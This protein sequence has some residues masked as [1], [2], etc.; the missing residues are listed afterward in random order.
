LD[1]KPISAEAFRSDDIEA[2]GV[3]SGEP[4]SLERNIITVLPSEL[5]LLVF[6]FLDPEDI[7]ATARTCTLFH[8]FTKDKSLWLA[9]S[10]RYYNVNPQAKVNDWRTYF[11]M[12]W[13]LS[14]SGSMQWVVPPRESIACLP[15]ERSRH[16]GNLVGDAIVFIGGND[17]RGDSFGDVH[18]FTPKT[19]KFRKKFVRNMPRSIARHSTCT[20]DEKIW[21]FGGSITTDDRPT[22]FK[23]NHLAKFDPATFRW[24]V[25][26]NVKGIPPSPRSDHGLAAVANC[27]YVF[28]G[29]NADVK[30]TADLFEFNTVTKTWT[31]LTNMTTGQ[32]PSPRSGHTMG[33]IGKKIFVFGGAVWSGEE[34]HDHSNELFV[35][36]TETRQWTKP[37]IH[38]QAPNVSIFATLF[39]IGP[40]V[41]IIGGGSMHS[42]VVLKEIRL[43]DT[44]NW[45]WTASKRKAQDLNLRELLYELK[46]RNLPTTGGDLIESLERALEKENLECLEI[47]G[48]TLQPLCGSVPT[49]FG[50]KVFLFGGFCGGP[51]NELRIIDLKW[52]QRLQ[53]SGISLESFN[54]CN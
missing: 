37:E 45:T 19:M 6:S 2:Q 42:P 33:S 7:P 54:L 26:E 4:L 5:I 47:E 17:K 12:K 8:H 15:E 31:E 10:T 23:T 20:I 36:D 48:P 16:S 35:F 50:N 3:E 1:G 22:K 18:I 49:V 9:L 13:T 14:Q 40:F 25:V 24:E 28:G 53:N 43:L 34:W 29:S 44:I 11:A 39:T 21:I 52:V 41:W 38:G 30:P 51:V 32:A 46:L 27:I